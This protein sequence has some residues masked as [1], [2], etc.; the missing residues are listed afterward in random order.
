MFK[1]FYHDLFS[2]VA[3]V[4]LALAGLTAPLQAWQTDNSIFKKL[5]IFMHFGVE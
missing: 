2:Y 4:A 3:S 1:Q 5:N